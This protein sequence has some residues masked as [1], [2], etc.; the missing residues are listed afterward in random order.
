MDVIQG[1]MNGINTAAGSLWLQFTI[2]AITICGLIWMFGSKDNAER[3]VTWVLIGSAA[4]LGAPR[5]AAWIQGL[6]PR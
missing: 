3:K 2:L 5:I 4:F 6:V 1:L